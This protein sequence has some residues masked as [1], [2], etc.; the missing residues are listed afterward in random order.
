MT[1]SDPASSPPRPTG[2]MPQTA[3]ITGAGKRIGRAI[4]LD[5]ADHGWAVAVHYNR[6]SGA[7]QEV[8]E[9]ITGAGGRAVAVGGDLTREAEVQAIVP[10]VVDALGPLGLLVNNASVFENDTVADATRESWDRHMEANLRAPVVLIQAFARQLPEDAAGAVVN[11]LDQRVWNPT[12][13]FMSYTV[14]KMGLWSLTRTLAMALAPRI[15]INAIGPGPT[16]KN[17]R[18]SDHHFER[19]W[20]AVP[21]ARPTDPAEVAEA[22]RYLAAAQAV[23]GQMLALDGGEHLGWAQ[24]SRGAVPVE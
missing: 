20:R 24:P 2:P 13:Y 21:L 7:A 9:Q 18:Q 19:Q 14:A 16:L 23:T 8:V 22:V 11:I 12:P 5:L 10:A 3:L 1:A 17:D 15:R 6:S 4:A